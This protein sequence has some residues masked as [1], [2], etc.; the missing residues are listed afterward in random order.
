MPAFLRECPLSS[1]MPPPGDQVLQVSNSLAEVCYQGKPLPHPPTRVLGTE[2][3]LYVQSAR[4]SRKHLG[5]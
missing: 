4:L 3:G 1:G 5:L 2:G